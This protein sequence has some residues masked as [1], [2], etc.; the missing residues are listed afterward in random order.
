MRLIARMT[1]TTDTARVPSANR[2]ASGRSRGT[3]GADG[4]KFHNGPLHLG[5]R[6]IS[7]IEGGGESQCEHEGEV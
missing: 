3:E 7:E 2:G 5:V 1:C 6:R 4:C